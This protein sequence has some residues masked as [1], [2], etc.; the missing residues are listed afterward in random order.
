MI[1]CWK[2]RGLWPVCTYALNMYVIYRTKCL[3]EREPWSD[4]IFHTLFGSESPPSALFGGAL[5]SAASISLVVIGG[6]G[7]CGV[8]LVDWMSVRSASG[9]YRKNTLRSM[10]TFSI[11]VSASLSVVRSAGITLPYCWPRFLAH[12]D[13]LYNPCGPCPTASSINIRN[14]RRRARLMILPF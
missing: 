12:F 11:L 9:G 4:S 10:S 5:R 6:S 14:P 1:D 3:A 8:I 2:C 13:T 7:C